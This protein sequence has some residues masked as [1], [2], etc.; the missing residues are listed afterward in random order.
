IF[1]GYDSAGIAD[2][3]MLD[4]APR[5]KSFTAKYND[6][7]YSA[8][9]KLHTATLTMQIPDSMNTNQNQVIAKTV[10]NQPTMHDNTIF[11][12]FL[13]FIMTQNLFLY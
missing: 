8:I 3:K 7:S 4:N 6:V 11:T 12:A 10:L 2:S 9:V 5:G 1:G 13:K